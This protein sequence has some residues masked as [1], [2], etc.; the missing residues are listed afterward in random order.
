MELF[1]RKVGQGSPLM[2]L[3]GVFGASE[4]WFTIA[5]QLGDAYTV[6]LLDLRNHGR[7]PHTEEM[8]Y[9]AMAADVQAF[10]QRHHLEGTALMGHSMGGKVAMWLA[11][12]Q[13][14]VI[15]RLIVVDI[16][17]KKYP[18]FHPDILE[19]LQ[20]LDL[21]KLRRREAADAHLAQFIPEARIRQFLLKNLIRDKQRQ[22]QWRINLKAILKNMPCILDWPEKP[23][24]F[25]KP[26]L[27]IRGENSNYILSEDFTGIRN[28][29]PRAYFVTIHQATHW[30][31]VDQ[32]TVFLQAVRYFLDATG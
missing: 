13:P 21:Q 9:P 23:G 19:G 12:H 17:P 29:F 6:Y 28:Q 2:I 18:A 32:P 26:T 24:T 16:A 22:F 8:S 31:H 1:F 25:E 15:S 20:S 14:Q 10:I 5:K 4:N 11:M 30:V 7:S 3:H 27:F